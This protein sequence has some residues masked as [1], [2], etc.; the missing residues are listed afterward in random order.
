[1]ITFSR[2]PTA[3]ER[4]R[5]FRPGWDFLRP[6]AKAHAAQP[7]PVFSLAKRALVFVG[8]FLLIAW[9]VVARVVL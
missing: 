5:R 3:H 6:L 2:W 7:G 1:M 4:T 8:G 9:I